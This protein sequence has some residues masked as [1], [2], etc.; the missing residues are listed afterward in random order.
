MLY[1]SMTGFVRFNTLFIWFYCRHNYLRDDL[2][3]NCHISVMKMIHAAFALVAASLLP[4]ATALEPQSPAPGAR[5]WTV[6]LNTEVTP[7][8]HGE[9]GYPYRAA[10]LGHDGSCDVR[11]DVNA[12]GAV[13]D[14][15][16]L[17]CTTE[18]FQGEAASV[19]QGLS[20][21]SGKAVDNA[22]LQ[23]RWTIEDAKAD[24][25]TASL[26]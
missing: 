16:V 23:I 17:A 7:L 10:S 11:F 4:S 1:C 8:A 13:S 9:V 25:Q 3:S 24:V 15:H 5:A 14:V 12:D 22:R 18:H 19:A 2:T 6:S 26:N 20:F 21:P